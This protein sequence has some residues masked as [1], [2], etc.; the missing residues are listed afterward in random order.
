MLSRY[1]DKQVAKSTNCKGKFQSSDVER[2]SS[3]NLVTREG[4]AVG[5]EMVEREHR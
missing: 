3:E 4:F 5:S 2:V 1:L